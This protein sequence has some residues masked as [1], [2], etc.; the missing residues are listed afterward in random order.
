MVENS[1][2]ECAE[3]GTLSVFL[4]GLGQCK[5]DPVTQQLNPINPIDAQIIY[6]LGLII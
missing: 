2:L 3:H 1:H 6:L 4:P 5:S